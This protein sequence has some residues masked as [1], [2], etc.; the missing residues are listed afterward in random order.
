[1]VTHGIEGKHTWG[2]RGVIW[3]GSS[4]LQVYG[5][6]CGRRV[7]STRLLAGNLVG[8]LFSLD[9]DDDDDDYEKESIISTNT[10]IFEIPSSDAITTSL[11]VLPIE[12]PDDS[13]IIG[14]EELNTIPEKELDEFIKS[15]VEDLVPIPSESEDTSGSKSVCILPSC[16]D[17]S[18]IDI[19]KE[20]VVAFT[21][22]L[23][24][25][26][27]DLISSDDESLSDEDNIESK[28]SYDYNLDESTFLVTPFFDA[29]K[30]DCFDLG[31]DDDEINVLDCEDGYYDSKRDILYIESLLNDDLVRRDPSIPAM[32]IAPDLEASRAR[33]FV[34]HPLELQSLAYGNPISYILLI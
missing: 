29:N 20:K 15:S 31:G 7:N 23:F 4:R 25:S 11:P 32:R 26:N 16:D 10:D 17:F 3:K 8:V 19:P 18:P 24:T 6:S 2:G 13:L 5:S 27:D 1:I 30:D 14:N 33:G 34:H 28:D 12:D 22:P 21:N 9:G